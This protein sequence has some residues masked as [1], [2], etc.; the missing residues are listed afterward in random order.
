DEQDVAL[1]HLDVAVPLL[2]EAEALVVVVDRHGQN[3]LGALLADDVQV[4]LVLDGAGR[5]DVGQQRPGTAAAALRLLDDRL[6]QLDAL[7]AD[8]HVAGPFDERPDVA[9]ALATEGAIGVAIA[10]G[11]AGRLA[12]ASARAR[13]F[14]RHAISLVTS[15]RPAWGSGL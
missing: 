12:P 3:L 1:V 2:A 9:V 11:V 14:G 5:R 6:A 8:V 13:V 4:Q 10:A 7:A 15:A